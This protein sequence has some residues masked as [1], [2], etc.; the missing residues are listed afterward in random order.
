MFGH[1]PEC[2]DAVVHAL[3]FLAPQDGPGAVEATLWI[4]EPSAEVDAGGYSRTGASCNATLRFDD[5]AGVLLDGFAGQNILQELHIADAPSEPV[6]RFGG[7]RPVAVHFEST[8]GGD[9][10]FRCARVSVRAVHVH[11]AAV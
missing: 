3:R 8:V 1:W 4:G 7:A 6:P 2:H 9:L 5:V 11:R 10:R